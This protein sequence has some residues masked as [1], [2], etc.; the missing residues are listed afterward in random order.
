MCNL[1]LIWYVFKFSMAHD[2]ASSCL[3]V[4]DQSLSAV[5]NGDLKYALV[6]D[7]R[8]NWHLIKTRHQSLNSGNQ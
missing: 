4:S 2:P 1:L 7:H 5:V 3:L 8:G 6:L